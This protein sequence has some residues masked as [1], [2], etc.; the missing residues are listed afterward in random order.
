VPYACALPASVLSSVVL[1]APAARATSAEGDGPHTL[2][3]RHLF[4]QCQ[5]T[6]TMLLL[7]QI[8]HHCQAK[9]GFHQARL[10]ACLPAPPEGPMM[11]VMCAARS[12]PVTPASTGLPHDLSR[13]PSS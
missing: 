12:T 3:F 5:L 6:S 8:D 11:A 2:V 10:P 4:Q 13:R 9:Q 7:T 1:P